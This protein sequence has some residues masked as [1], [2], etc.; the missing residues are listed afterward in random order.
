MPPQHP[1]AIVGAGVA[2]LLL[3]LLLKPHTQNIVLIDPHHD[4]GDLVRRWH[5]VVSNM[6]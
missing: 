1:I 5:A 4:G 6:R 3:V 2:G